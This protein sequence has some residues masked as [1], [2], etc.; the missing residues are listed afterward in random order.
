ME[1]SKLEI[2]LAATPGMV[3][4]G[5]DKWVENPSGAAS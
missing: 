5:A 2:G 3:R 1:T 4:A